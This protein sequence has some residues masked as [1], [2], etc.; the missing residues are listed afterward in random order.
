MG[1]QS[2]CETYPLPNAKF[3]INNAT[4]GNNVKIAITMMPNSTNGGTPLT[5]LKNGSLK[6]AEAVNISQPKGGVAEPTAP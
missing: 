2:T 6:I 3:G 5:T 1:S 4:L